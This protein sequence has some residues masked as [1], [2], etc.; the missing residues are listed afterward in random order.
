MFGDD[1]AAGSEDDGGQDEEVN[2]RSV[3][4]E[5]Q[6]L[7]V[8]QSFWDADAVAVERQI[9]VGDKVRADRPY[10]ISEKA[11]DLLSGP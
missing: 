6:V 5:V 3:Q 10:E 1:Q 11:R 9:Q 2:D 4:P 7:R 8:D